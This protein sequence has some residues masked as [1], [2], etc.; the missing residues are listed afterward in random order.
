MAYLLLRREAWTVNQKRVNRLWGEEVTWTVFYGA[1]H[2]PGKA[3]R[4]GG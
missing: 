4:S 2:P 3:D 1:D